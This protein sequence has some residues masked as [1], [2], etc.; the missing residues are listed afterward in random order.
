M[1]LKSLWFDQSGSKEEED[2]DVLDQ[3][4][5]E[6]MK[7][8]ASAINVKH[9]D[10][11]NIEEYPRLIIN[12]PASVKEGNCMCVLLKSFLCATKVVFEKQESDKEK[13]KVA[14]VTRI[15]RKA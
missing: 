10:G 4:D 5:G 15:M 14:H 6:T 2:W 12:N 1:D 3:V 13:A 11:N 8:I 9:L 7:Q